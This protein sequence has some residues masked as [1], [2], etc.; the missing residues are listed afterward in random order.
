MGCKIQ[1]GYNGDIYGGQNIAAT[2]GIAHTSEE[3]MTAWYNNEIDLSCGQK[4]HA[5]QM[6]FRSSHY[7][8]CAEVEK[9]MASGAKCSSIQV[10]RYLASGN[11]NMSPGNWLG[12][13]LDD[14]VI[15]GPACPPKGCF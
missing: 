11:C 9:K 6:V 2:I 1:H 3:I 7:V 14:K 4:G 5:T 8:G 13:T 10:C 15:C 12:R